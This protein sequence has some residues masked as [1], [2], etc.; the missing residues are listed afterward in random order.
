MQN[1]TGTQV[2]LLIAAVGLV[3]G[4]I[5]WLGR[6]LTFVLHRW[7]TGSPK[8]DDAAYLNSVADLAAKLRAN[9]MTMEDVRQL[10]TIMQTPSAIGSD[11]AANIVEDMSDETAEPA[12]FHSNLAMQGRTGAENA[13]AEAR[14]EQALL[15][16]H[17]LL[18]EHEHEA[19]DTVQARWMEYR[20]A[21]RNLA[22]LEFQGGTHAP[23]AALIAGLTETERRT[24]EIRA[25]VEERGRR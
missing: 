7:W 23:L 22:Y 18:H 6:G 12:A 24:E 2:T 10:E 17:L 16:L 1:L 4:F 3:A 20:D 21:L 11:A 5:G 13:V 14:L 8:R 9:G 15:D 19:L 25:Q